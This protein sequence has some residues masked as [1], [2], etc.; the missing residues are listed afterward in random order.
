[1]ENSLDDDAELDI[2]YLTTEELSKL[3]HCNEDIITKKQ[4]DYLRIFFWAF[5]SCGLRISDI[6]TL[7]W[8]DLNFDKKEINKMQMKSRHS[9][10]IPLRNEAIDILNPQE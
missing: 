9:V 3:T 6:M 4:K 8:K 5:Y 2:K 7:R 10:S 1:M